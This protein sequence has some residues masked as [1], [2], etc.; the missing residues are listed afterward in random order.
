MTTAG[1]NP[2]GRPRRWA[3]AAGLAFKACVLALA[4][5]GF[6]ANTADPDLWGHVLFGHRVLQ[7]GVVD[8]VD[9][10]SWTATGAPWINHEAL[11]EIL[12]ALVHRVAGGAGLFWMMTCCGLVTWWLALRLGAERLDR[13][14]RWVAWGVAALASVE[15]AFGFAARPQ[16]FTGLALV[17]LLW[18]L[19]RIAAGRVGWAMAL[20]LL[21]ALWIN[22]HGGALAGAV[23]LWLTAF[24]AGPLERLA[25]RWMPL[26]LTPRRAHVA[27]WLAAVAATMALLANP[28]GVGLFRWLAASVSWLR[29]EIAEWNPTP[30]GWDHAPFFAL[31]ALVAGAW[32]FSE[33]PKSLWE[34]AVLGAL[35]VAALRSVRHTP[36]FCI[37]A[38]ALAPPYVADALRRGQ[39]YLSRLAELVRQPGTQAAACLTFTLLTAAVVTATW[40][41][42][43]DTF[44]TMAVPRAQYPLAAIEF[45]RQHGL[46][47]NLL[48]FFDWGELCLWELPESAVSFDGRLDTCYPRPLIA[49]H[50]KFYRGLPCTAALLDLDKASIALLPHLP[51]TEWLARQ[52]GWTVAYVDPLAVV[53]VHDRMRFPGLA[54]LPLPVQA[55]APAVT[56]RARFPDALPLRLRASPLA[57]RAGSS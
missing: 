42:D 53:L 40:Q 30:W 27:L 52:P 19:R 39:A 43:R 56:G 38:L 24:S 44:G 55:G 35:A 41:R 33:R 14:T 46:T 13:S 29:P 50:W 20:P 16:M 15:I 2:D 54:A 12:M 21:F 51:G 23:L 26:T 18:L 34:A 47:G 49:E 25:G 3:A 5:Y 9:S 11:A 6:A 36:L 28:W 45:I 32:L 17:A 57:I 37:A 48:V 22:L 7:T 8:R 10:Y 4:F 1:D 31:L